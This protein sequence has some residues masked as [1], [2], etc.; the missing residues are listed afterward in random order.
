MSMIVYYSVTSPGAS[1]YDPGW[2]TSMQAFFG[3][4]CDEGNGGTPGGLPVGDGP[5]PP[6][7]IKQFGTPRLYQNPTPPAFTV[8]QEYAVYEFGISG[9][10]ESEAQRSLKVPGAPM[11]MWLTWNLTPGVLTFTQNGT[12]G[13]VTSFQGGHCYLDMLWHF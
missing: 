13:G 3:L 8:H 2:W 12:S 5:N 11:K 1:N 4:W 6:W 7:V 9:T 10:V